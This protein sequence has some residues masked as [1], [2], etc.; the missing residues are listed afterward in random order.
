MR[1]SSPIDIEMDRDGLRLCAVVELMPATGATLAAWIVLGDGTVPI[2]AGAAAVGFALGAAVLA[3]SAVG[4]PSAR[5][6]SNAARRRLGRDAGLPGDLAEGDVAVAIDLGAWMLRRFVADAGRGGGVTWLPARRCGLQ[7]RWHGLR[8]AA[9]S[10]RS[11]PGI[12]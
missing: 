8:C 10:P 2:A 1:A 3:L 9:S 12:P 4:S 5:L 6:R 11:T 7:A